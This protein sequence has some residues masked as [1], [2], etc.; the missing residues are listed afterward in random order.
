MVNS[1]RSGRSKRPAPP[2]RRHVQSRHRPDDRACRPLPT[3]RPGVRVRPPENLRRL[4]LEV[5]AG[6]GTRRDPSTWAGFSPAA[7]LGHAP[8]P[9]AR[10]PGRCPP[11]PPCPQ[12]FPFAQAGAAPHRSPTTTALVAVFLRPRRAQAPAASRRPGVRRAPLCQLQPAAGPRISSTWRTP[13][14][15]VR[16]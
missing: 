10:R 15:T 14:P 3:P 7:V 4:Q 12:G 13:S 6:L 8:R 11:R 5:E 2:K 1:Y 16:A 9:V